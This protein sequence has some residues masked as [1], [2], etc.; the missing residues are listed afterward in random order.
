LLTG[1]TLYPGRLYI[2]DFEAYVASVARLVEMVPEA[3][4]C[5]VMGTHV[6]MTQTPGVD[7]D[8][9]ADQHP[10]EHVLQL[11]WAHLVELN[12]AVAAMQSP[13]I[14]IHDDFIVYPL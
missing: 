6:E 2:D 8:F 13:Q 14:E 7:F 12:D 1:D 9:G 5:N 11:E 4:V 3:D 10:D